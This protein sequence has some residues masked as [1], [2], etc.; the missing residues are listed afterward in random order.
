MPGSALVGLWAHDLDHRSQIKLLSKAGVSNR[1]PTSGV[2]PLY[3]LSIWL[4]QNGSTL[5]FKFGVWQVFIC[6]LAPPVFFSLKCLFK[7]FAHLPLSY[8]FL[9][10]LHYFL[11]YSGY[12]FF[13]VIYMSNN[14]SESVIFVLFLLCSIFLL[15]FLVKYK[16]INLYIHGLCFVCLLQK[17]IPYPPGHRNT[18]L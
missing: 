8:L 1:N 13:S 6:L 16:F 17:V 11:I 18:F 7:S 9:I 12:Q 4:T 15:T 10:Y 14:F 5:Y 3:F 2:R